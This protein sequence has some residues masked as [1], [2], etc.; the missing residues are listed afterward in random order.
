MHQNIRL[1]NISVFS[2]FFDY[3]RSPSSFVNAGD[4][5][6]LPNAP[7]LGRHKTRIP[8]RRDLGAI[9]G[10]AFMRTSGASATQTSENSQNA[11]QNHWVEKWSFL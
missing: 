5:T 4:E 1:R 10:A 11:K 2:F 6:N 7:S 3:K 9:V 8:K